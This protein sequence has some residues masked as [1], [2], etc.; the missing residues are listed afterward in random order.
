MQ[1]VAAD[2]ASGESICRTTKGIF[3]LFLLFYD[4]ALVPDTPKKQEKIL[5]PGSV[6]RRFGE[7]DTQS[8][9]KRLVTHSDEMLGEKCGTRV[10]R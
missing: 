9:F 3:L 2:L 7:I 6:V 1:I 5:R 4:H 8:V 10:W